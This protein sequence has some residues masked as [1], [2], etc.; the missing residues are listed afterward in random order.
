[1]ECPCSVEFCIDPRCQPIGMCGRDN[2]KEHD[3]E[4]PRDAL[5]HEVPTTAVRHTR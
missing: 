2:S 4:R 5:E 1:M 3:L